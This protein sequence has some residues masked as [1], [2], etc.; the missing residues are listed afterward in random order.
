MPRQHCTNFPNI[1][2]ETFQANIE[3]KGKIVRNR[4]MTLAQ[5]FSIQLSV[6]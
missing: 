4:N 1:A 5:V 2:Q 6:H 3:Q